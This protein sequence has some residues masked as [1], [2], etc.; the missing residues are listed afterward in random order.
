[1]ESVDLVLAAVA[2][3]ANLAVAAVLLA[4]SRGGTAVP[5]IFGRP[6]P[7]PRLRAAM[8]TCLGLGMGVGWL[9]EDVFPPR[10]LGDTVLFYVVTILLATAVVT[11]LLA[12]FR[13]PRSV[14]DK[15]AS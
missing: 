11:G 7:S 6:Q 13:Y 10:S 14:R 12:A 1:M 5:R 4:R 2:A 3:G 8:H 9:L 15:A